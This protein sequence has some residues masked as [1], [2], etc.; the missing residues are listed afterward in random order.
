MKR[1]LLRALALLAVVAALAGGAVL[2]VRGRG[3]RPLR[4]SGRT[5]APDGKPLA[6]VQITLEIAPND[7]EEEG[8][9]ER[10]GTLSDERGEFSI[11]YQSHWKNASY[12]LE[13]HKAGYRELS[14]GAAET[15]KPPVMLRLAP[16]NP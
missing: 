9:V 4:I 11:E 7:T 3:P 6:D 12:R 1:P 15:L 5:I 14:V 13:A 2:Y 16:V 10:A 8:A